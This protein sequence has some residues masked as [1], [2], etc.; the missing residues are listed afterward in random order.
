LRS[1][2]HNAD[3]VGPNSLCIATPDVMRP[4]RFC[5]YHGNGNIRHNN[6][7]PKQDASSSSSQVSLPYYNQAVAKKS[8]SSSRTSINT[9][10]HLV[11]GKR[12]RNVIFQYLFLF[13]DSSSP[14]TKQTS[15]SGVQLYH[16][17]ALTVSCLLIGIQAWRSSLI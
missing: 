4:K 6:M 3:I 17:C 13:S 15:E 16:T 1:R 12:Q 9:Y 11:G 14:C 10:A 7:L 8:S 5:R 2:K